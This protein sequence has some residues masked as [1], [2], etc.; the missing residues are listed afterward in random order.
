MSNS[1]V[2][3]KL[4][5]FYFVSVAWGETYRNY[6]LEY[7]LPTLLAL[8]NIPAIANVRPSKFLIATTAVD[9]EIIRSTAVFRELQ[10]HTEPLFIELPPPR[11]DR[12]Y[13]EQAIV[14]H[15]ICCELA[16]SDKAIRI[17]TGPDAVYSD[18]MVAHLH[19]LALEGADAVLSLVTPLTRT[20][21][22]IK[23]LSELGLRP[24]K[25]ARDTG[26]PITITPRQI[27]ALAMR[28]MHGLSR[29]NEWEAPYFWRYAA[30]PWWRV[31][32]GQGG[33]MNGNFWDLLM[34]DYSAVRHDSSLLDERGWD[35]DYIMRTI[36][37]LETIYFVRDSDEMHVVSWTNLPEPRLRRRYGGEFVKGAAFRA[38]AYNPVFNNFQRD[39]LFM[40]TLVHCGDLNRDWHEIEDK[41][42]QTIATWLDTPTEIERYSRR[43]PPH[44]RNYAGLQAR[45]EACDLS[46]WRRNR[47]A[48]RWVLFVFVPA[49]RLWVPTREFLINVAPLACKR[50]ALALRG[51][52]ASLERL[53]WR[54]RELLARIFGRP[55]D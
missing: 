47:I 7:C 48:W 41:A 5:S 18:G 43:L 39:A 16:A 34:V 53:R 33:V 30:T 6:F 14:G 24:R 55:L 1:T 4:R 51:D 44:L 20:E 25:S 29:I 38:S 23:T 8:G 9:W 13:W 32:G 46:W 2:S 27:A 21:L 26:I 40:S 11:D 22:F 35:G 36:G 52:S 10:K 45:I 3:A 15:K 12:Y 42:L 28:A 37:N 49:V 19:Q 54:G 31:S 17:F 50:I